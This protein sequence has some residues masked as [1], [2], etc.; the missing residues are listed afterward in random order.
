MHE[1]A[2]SYTPLGMQSGRMVTS[3]SFMIDQ[4]AVASR[5]G[6]RAHALGRE[7]WDLSRVSA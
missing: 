6:A 1:E 4:F 7:L 2:L 3:G 5:A